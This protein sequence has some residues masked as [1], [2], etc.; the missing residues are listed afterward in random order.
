V[1][2]A[3]LGEGVV[4]VDDSSNDFGV[5]VATTAGNGDDITL[6]A[7]TN[8]VFLRALPGAVVDLVGDGEAIVLLGE[9]FGDFDTGHC[10]GVS[11]GGFALATLTA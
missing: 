7:G 2:V 1:A 9:G 10:F 11:K 8:G 5:G 3:E 6:L 4:L